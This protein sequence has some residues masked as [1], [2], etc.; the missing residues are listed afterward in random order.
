[1]PVYI[2]DIAIKQFKRQNIFASLKDFI[3][4]LPLNI[5]S[6]H[7]I[8]SEQNPG[9]KFSRVSSKIEDTKTYG[10]LDQEF[11]HNIEKE[12]PDTEGTI[13]DV[14]NPNSQNKDP[15]KSVPVV[16]KIEQKPYKDPYSFREQEGYPKGPG[17]FDSDY[18]VRN[19]YRNFDSS[20]KS[21]VAIT[22]T[23]MNPIRF[24]IPIGQKLATKWDEIITGLNPSI[25]KSSKECNVKLKKAD[26]SK[27]RWTFSVKSK[28]SDDTHTVHVKGVIR[29][30]AKSLKSLDLKV[31]CSCN[32]WKW[33]GPDYH[34]A[35]NDYLDMSPRSNG[36]PPDDKDPTGKNRV[37]KHV[38]AASK[39]FLKYALKTQ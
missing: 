39:L 37:C 13:Y 15:E 34:A 27:G 17:S 26:P 22:N 29:K 1:M 2:S 18:A 5:R 8:S 12:D 32:F 3:D 14:D 35:T 23:Y 19:F 36:S 16:R 10:P 6:Y 33:Q 24:F 7:V 11:V 25:V 9:P 4:V 28:D 30:N 31:G 38:Y 21:I 20:D